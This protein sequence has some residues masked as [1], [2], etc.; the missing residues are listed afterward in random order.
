MK[1]L[2]LFIV[3]FTVFVSYGQIVSFVPS[4]DTLFIKYKV[5]NVTKTIKIY[6]G[7]GVNAATKQDISDSLRNMGWLKIGQRL[8]LDNN[9]ITIA[10]SNSGIPFSAQI[11]TTA[12]IG[13]IGFRLGQSVMLSGNNARYSFENSGYIGDLWSAPL[14]FERDWVLPNKSGTIAMVSDLPNDVD[15]LGGKPASEYLV[16]KDSTE[17]RVFSDLKYVDKSSAQIITGQKTF[18]NNKTV[19]DGDSVVITKNLHI[20]TNNKFNVRENSI[21]QMS[22]TINS[23]DK[24]TSALFI[25]DGSLQ[26]GVSSG[27]FDFDPQRSIIIGNTLGVNGIGGIFDAED[28]SWL[29]ENPFS[30]YSLGGVRTDGDILATGRLVLGDSTLIFPSTDGSVGQVLK[31]DGNGNLYFGQ[32]ATGNGGAAYTDS[33]AKDGRHITTDSVTIKSEVLLKTQAPYLFLTSDWLNYSSPDVLRL[34]KNY[35][36]RRYN[37]GAYSDSWII[38]YA[39]PPYNLSANWLYPIEHRT[40]YYNDTLNTV[41]HVDI[42]NVDG[43]GTPRW[44]T[45]DVRITGNEIQVN[46]GDLPDSSALNWNYAGL[47]GNN[48]IFSEANKTS[49]EKRFPMPAYGYNFRF[50]AGTDYIYPY[51]YGINIDLT[52]GNGRINNGY[53]FRGI[54]NYPSYFGGDI[55][56]DGYIKV[57]DSIIIGSST[58]KIYPDSITI[59]G[60]RVAKITETGGVDSTVINDLIQDWKDSS[61]VTLIGTTQT[62]D[63]LITEYWNGT[64][65]GADST[66]INDL[67]QDWKDSSGTSLN[68]TANQIDS[69]LA[70]A[71]TALQSIGAGT[72]GATQLSSTTVTPGNYTNTNLTVDADG[73]IT[74]ASNGTGGG[75]AFDTTYVYQAIDALP[76]VG[77]VQGLINTSINALVDT[78]GY[79]V[80][81]IENFSSD[82]NP[83]V[84]N[85]QDSG[86]VLIIMATGFTNINSPPTGQ[87]MLT[88]RYDGV[89]ILEASSGFDSDGKA[90][91]PSTLSAYVVVDDTGDVNFG[92]YNGDNSWCYLQTATVITL[93]K[94]I[95]NNGGGAGMTEAEKIQHDFMWT[96]LALDTTGSIGTFTDVTNAPTST[97]ISSNKIPVTANDVVRLSVSTGEYRAYSNGGWTDW[98][99]TE[100]LLKDVDS[101]QVRHTSSGSVNATTNQTLY[102]SND[103]DVF[104]VTTGSGIPAAPTNFVAVGGT[105]T[106]EFTST[107]TE[108]GSLQN[109]KVLFY[110]GSSNDTTTLALVDSVNAGVGSYRYIDRTPNTVYWCGV[111]MRNTTGQLSYFSNLDSAKTLASGGATPFYSIGFESNNLSEFTSTSG[112]NISAS[113]TIAKT[114][115]YSMR[116]GTNSLGVYDFTDRDSI[117]VTF[118]IYLPSTSSQNATYNYI[119]LFDDGNTDKCNFGT[120]QSTWSEW[121]AGNN[122]GNMTAGLTTNFSEN[123]WHQIKHFYKKGTGANAIHK[124]WVDGTEIYSNTS[125]NNTQQV[126]TFSIGSQNATITNYFYIDDINFYNANPNP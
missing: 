124:V 88:I 5:L 101:V 73:R 84:I 82:N 116:V 3:L 51:F 66:I 41:T 44:K 55:L 35:A 15:S 28:R 53:L 104:S 60:T 70:L 119:S 125:A 112:A 11:N 37:N 18:S 23:N 110:A 92:L 36:E 99:S 57:Q 95:L 13:R 34:G 78:G 21:G 16:K 29:Y 91:I 69:L 114:G 39:I 46:I 96:Y 107:W 64:L 108:N 58:V 74:A 89:N 30:L 97:L 83:M 85:P 19:F 67:I 109:S 47:Y 6:S 81:K 12:D 7:I 123:T 105:H 59:G 98:L 75:S 93:K 1:R 50:G 77:E 27:D 20:G 121:I 118:E 102:V 79:Y 40:D 9:A 90:V 32:D 72:I 63:S 10:D 65:A 14:T 56:T 45:N 117:Y 17:L 120:N 42:L 52:G 100:K 25:G 113:N 76:T 26:I 62:L 126:G 68:Y 86:D 8:Y 22:V 61:G 103:N 54:G 33:I 31:T 38:D 115:T 94:G 24:T 106:N 49:G 111:K 2:I 43:T 48:V 122:S 4:G 80:A 71:G 87:T